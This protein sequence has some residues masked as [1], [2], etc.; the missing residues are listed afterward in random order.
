MRYNDHILMIG[1][2]YEAQKFD[3]FTGHLAENDIWKENSNS[4][5]AKMRAKF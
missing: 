2:A 4:K 3:K 5:I 1:V